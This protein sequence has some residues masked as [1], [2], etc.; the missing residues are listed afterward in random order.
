M[1]S[2]DMTSTN[3]TEEQLRILSELLAEADTPVKEVLQAYD[4]KLTYEEMLPKIETLPVSDLEATAVFLGQE[5]KSMTGQKKYCSERTLSDWIIMR[6]EA[7]FP[8]TCRECTESYTVKRTDTPPVRCNYCDAGLHNCAAILA[9]AGDKTKT[10][11]RIWMC[12]DCVSKH[13]L[14]RF[15]SHLPDGG[16]PNPTLN[17]TR[18]SSNREQV[19][20]RQLSH[21]IGGGGNNNHPGGR[22]NN[23]PTDEGTASDTEV[24]K[25][26]LQ[27]RCRHGRNG[28]TRVGNRTCPKAHPI[29]CKKF[30]NYGTMRGAGCNVTNCN[31]FHPPLCKNSERRHECLKQNCTKQHLKDT[32]R[33]LPTRVDNEPRNTGNI[34]NARNNRDRNPSSWS[35]GANQASN[36]ESRNWSSE[37]NRDRIPSRPQWS[38]DQYR[39][40]SNDP[41]PAFLD[42]IIDRLRDSIAGI[43]RMEMRNRP[44]RE[45]DQQ[46]YSSQPTQL[47][48][49]MGNTYSPHHQRDRRSY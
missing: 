31:F 33:S 36:P 43:V 39:G 5:V 9:E 47:P 20:G 27:R 4:P 3:T 40:Q 29:L 16:P 22:G 21:Q 44:E 35:R 1:I 12:N 30:C 38:Q 14:E 10:R 8:Q 42:A 2:E 46:H 37:P 48:P 32:R 15:N 25:F 41:D 7:L 11:S 18:R 19:L 45:A 24:C 26:Y 28:T 6:I 49:G 17:S 34:G 13:T 23:S